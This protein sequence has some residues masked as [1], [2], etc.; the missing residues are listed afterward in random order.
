MCV[1]VFHASL[2]KYNLHTVKFTPK[3]HNSMSFDIGI[4]SRNHNQNVKHF[5][6]PRKWF[7]KNFSKVGGKSLDKHCDTALCCWG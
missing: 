3:V 7:I 5:Y 2:L 1:S 6:H 4:Q